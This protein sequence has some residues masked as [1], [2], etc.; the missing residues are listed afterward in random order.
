MT[1]KGF[2]PTSFWNQEN[3]KPNSNITTNFDKKVDTIYASNTLVRFGSANALGLILYIDKIDNY[4]DDLVVVEIMKSADLANPKKYTIADLKKEP[5]G[6]SGNYFMAVSDPMSVTE[7]E[8][9][10]VFKVYNPKN[11]EDFTSVT[12]NMEHFVASLLECEDRREPAIKALWD[13][14]YAAK[15]YQGIDTSVGDG[16]TGGIILDT[17]NIFDADVWD[18]IENE[19]DNQTGASGIPRGYVKL[20]ISDSLARLL[21]IFNPLIRIFFDFEI[22]EYESA[23]YA[24]PY[25]YTESNS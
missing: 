6:T 2:A 5:Y 11:S 17:D 20:N 1:E 7:Y 19:S 24:R 12:Y 23:W 4:A 9:K 8:Q 21:S 3:T 25:P 15:S 22:V 13:Y 14:Y 10:Y 18:K 16:T